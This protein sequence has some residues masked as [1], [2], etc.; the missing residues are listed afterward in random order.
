M[1]LLHKSVLILFI[2]VLAAPLL[3]LKAGAAGISTSAQS[4]VL[5]EQGSGRI[6]YAKDPHERRRIASITKIMTAVIAIES[7]KMHKNV[8]VTSTAAGTEGSSLYLKPGQ[9]MKLEDLVYGLMLRSGNDAAAAIAEYVGGSLDGFAMLMNQKA[10]QLGMNDSHFTNPHGLDNTKDHY[11][12]AFDMALLTRYAMTLKDYREIAGTKVHKAPNPYENWDYTWRNKNRLLTQLYK[13][14]TGGKTGYTKLARRTLVTTAEKDGL[15]LIAVTLNDG[16]DWDDHKGMFEYGFNNYE[17]TDLMEAGKIK[18]I[19]DK[20]YK[21][22]IYARNSFSYP[23]TEEEA[24]GVT[25]QL[26]LLK[27]KQDWKDSREVP[28]IVGKKVFYLD[29]KEIGHRNIFYGKYK[30]PAKPSWIQSFKKMF[31]TAI[32]IRHG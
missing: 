2:F 14:C 12:S 20:V 29:G 28:Q 15:K 10:E 13:Y 5:M 6:L 31:L 11:S 4:A 16:N 27:P 32:G 19:A 3:Q 25:S 26:K 21:G 18:R 9:K 30:E 17:V 7:G 24:A 8:T 22:K 23:L 1:K